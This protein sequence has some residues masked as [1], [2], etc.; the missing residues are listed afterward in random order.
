M[1]ANIL[2]TVD[3]EFIEKL[4]IL[5]EQARVSKDE[6]SLLFLLESEQGRWFLMRM[7]DR[8]SVLANI[9]PGD[10]PATN[11]TLGARSIGLSY[12]QDIAAL[13]MKGFKL[14][15]QAELEYATANIEIDETIK[16]LLASSESEKGE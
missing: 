6:Q 15:Q 2:G 7:L 12:L 10:G 8:C 13:D 14:K 5:T 11:Y 9:P 3:D 16:K 1:N 4:Q